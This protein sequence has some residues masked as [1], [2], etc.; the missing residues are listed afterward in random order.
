MGY[1]RYVHIYCT[2]I[3]ALSRASHN[4]WYTTRRRFRPSQS[5]AVFV[6]T[7]G[8]ISPE[9]FATKRCDLDDANYPM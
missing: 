4:T 3:L 9:G 5:L 8:A 6:P 2:S 7:R 1:H